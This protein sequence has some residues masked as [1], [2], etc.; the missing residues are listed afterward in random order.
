VLVRDSCST[1]FSPSARRASHGS[2]NERAE[3]QRG[4]SLCGLLNAFRFRSSYWT[5]LSIHLPRA[6]LSCVVNFDQIAELCQ[7]CL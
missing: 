5:L 3:E 4:R 7:D 6:G 1:R 2:S